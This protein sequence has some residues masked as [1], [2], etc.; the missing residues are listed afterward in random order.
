M[1]QSNEL[2]LSV[3]STDNN[4]NGT[5]EI[6]EDA[7]LLSNE[8]KMSG[9]S[10][11]NSKKARVVKTYKCILEFNTCREAIERLKEPI[12]D[13][14]YRFRYTRNS[15]QGEKDFYHCDGN[16][17]CPK[18]IYVLRH[19]DSI[20][21]TVW[22]AKNNHHHKDS[23]VGNLPPKSVAHIKK[24]LEEKT[25]Y[26]NNEIMNSLRRH[27]C[28]QLTKLQINNLKQRLKEKRIG[29]SNCCI[30]EIKD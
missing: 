28:P 21:A 22:L 9:C 7:S 17:K 23:A 30:H 4:E 6:N 14:R 1:D 20:K 15:Q 8:S 27:N 12:N 19:N 5:N 16:K 29:K 26:S 3:D 18:T 11:N 25:R 10:N 13:S 2:R 24:L